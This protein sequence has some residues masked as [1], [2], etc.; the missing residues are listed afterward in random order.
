[1]AVCG[2]NFVGEARFVD[3]KKERLQMAEAAGRGTGEKFEWGTP[4]N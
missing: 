2:R 4:I 1:M 3:G